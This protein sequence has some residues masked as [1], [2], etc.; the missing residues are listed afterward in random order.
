MNYSLKS[1]NSHGHLLTTEFLENQISQLPDISVF[2]FDIGNVLLKLNYDSVLEKLLRNS[3]EVDC[4][5]FVQGL[6]EI[7][8]K[9]G[10][11]RGLTSFDPFFRTLQMK[12]PF[13]KSLNQFKTFWNS[14]FIPDMLMLDF[15]E[16]ISRNHRCCI[17]S[18]TN[19]EHFSFLSSNFQIFNHMGNHFLSYDFQ[20]VKEDQSFFHKVSE[21]LETANSA[22]LVI[23]DKLCN[24]HS[25]LAAGC[26][27]IHHNPDNS[28]LTIE[29]VNYILEHQRK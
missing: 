2:A 23:D 24:I 5:Q 9:T 4:N 19:E 25:A 26:N 3:S 28:G 18:D 22:I 20:C 21:K 12:F 11:E 8:E 10:L 7:M 1:L 13:L 14:I 15:A 29:L 6:I 16:N 17:V 27:A